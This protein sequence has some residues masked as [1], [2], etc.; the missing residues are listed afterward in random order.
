MFSS[1]FRASAPVLRIPFF[2]TILTWGFFEIC[3]PIEELSF[4]KIVREGGVMELLEASQ[5]VREGRL[6]CLCNLP[7]ATKH[8]SDKGIVR[9]GDQD[10]A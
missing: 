8:I 2:S 3:V 4:Q 6:I 10:E 9:V 1:F 7:V 5:N